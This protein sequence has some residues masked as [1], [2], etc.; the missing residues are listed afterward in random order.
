MAP[1]D[2]LAPA[3]QE[4]V[5]S[6]LRRA[7]TLGGKFF[8]RIFPFSAPLSV[9]VGSLFSAQ[10][11]KHVGITPWLLALTTLVGAMGTT[12]REFGEV[13]KR[14]APLVLNLLILH[15]F[16][17]LLA[18]GAGHLLYPSAPEIQT[19]LL[20][21]TV[22]PTGVTSMLWVSLYRGNIPLTLAMILLDTLLSPIVVPWSLAIFQGALPGT[23]A[24]PPIEINA[25]AMLW[26]LLWMV[27]I[28]SLLGVAL[29]VGSRGRL[30]RD[31]S[32]R[33]VPYTRISVMILIALNSATVGPQLRVVDETLVQL[34]L[35]VCV[36]AS[37]GYVLGW[38][39]SRALGWSREVLV[40]MT[41]NSGMRNV[42]AGAVLA[43]TYFPRG[44]VLPVI[45]GMLF[46][47]LLAA[48]FGAALERW[49]GETGENA[50]LG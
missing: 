30:Q 1:P 47:Q 12:F 8:Q 22:I 34:V 48:T 13:L 2:L 11:E 5:R 24:G 17:P 46:Q 23:H 32:P 4:P 41:F 16:V 45:L 18:L 43:V 33:L 36:L 25:Q 44:A 31:W 14:P 7:L 35:L 28:P 50:D 9:L 42:S 3:S 6:V 49:Q 38:L 19:G 29:N 21:G 26:G 40:T 20:L 27:V 15:G 39:L 37:S 10:L